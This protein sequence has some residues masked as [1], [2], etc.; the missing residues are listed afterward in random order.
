MVSSGT[1]DIFYIFHFQMANNLLA[2]KFKD[3]AV[4]ISFGFVLSGFKLIKKEGI[5]LIYKKTETKQL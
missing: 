3:N 5:F 4:I 2:K 1:A